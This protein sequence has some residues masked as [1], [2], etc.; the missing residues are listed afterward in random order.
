M[1]DKRILLGEFGRAQGVRGEVRI[2]SYTD[3]PLAIA[4]Y[5]PLSDESGVRV[6]KILSARAHQADMIV[7]R[8]EGVSDRSAAEALTR[9]KIFAPREALKAQKLDDGEFLQAD[10]VGLRVRDTQG[11]AIGR[12]VGIENYG[13]GD[14]LAIEIAGKKEPALLPFSDAF[15]PAI[16]VEAGVATIDP[17]DGWDEE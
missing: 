14:L 8:I 13:A 15:V 17:P 9:M 12:I 1:P 16:D 6:F 3:D 4:D 7:A 10:L 2:K 11:R 5:A